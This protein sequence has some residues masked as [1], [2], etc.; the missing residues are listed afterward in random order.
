MIPK[1]H[2]PELDPGWEPVFGKACPDADPGIMLS[3]G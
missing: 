3:S 2:V 1:Q